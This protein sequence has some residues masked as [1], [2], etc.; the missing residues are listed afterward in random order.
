MSL[1]FLN[2]LYSQETTVCYGTTKV[3]SVDTD[4]GVNGTAGS[5]YS[6][7]IKNADG[8][9]NNT[10]VITTTTTSGNTISV[11]WD[12]TSVGTYTL[13]VVEDNTS[14]VASAVT[15]SVNIK[16]N[17]IVA[18]T[19]VS[20]CLA[21]DTTILAT[22]NPSNGSDIFDW[23]TPVAYTGSTNSDTLT[24]T[25]AAANMAGN[26]TVTVTDTDGC[27]SA[28]AVAVLTVNP[29]PDATIIPITTTEFCSGG[30]VVLSAPTGL[31]YVWNKDGVPIAPISTGD[32]YTAVQSGSYTVTTKD[33][34]NCSSTT[35][36][37]ISV[38]VNPNPTVSVVPSTTEFCDGLSAT[39]TA[40]PGL[41]TPPYSYQWEDTNGNITTN[42]TNASYIATATSDYKVKITDDKGCNVTSDVQSISNRPNPDSSVSAATPTTFCAGDSVVLQSGNAARSGYTYQW[43]KDGVDIATASTN[44]NYTANESGSFTVRVVDTNFSTNCTTS[45][46]SAIVVT[47]T[48]LPITSGITAH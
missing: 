37:G 12:T 15:L 41:G 33:T 38:I 3:Y 9:V 42:G 30:S 13:E 44:F 48:N 27:V 11:N 43:I 16:A 8:T 23:T 21:A 29:L 20:V 4:D 24:I 31:S 2:S 28:P 5:T 34:N 7:K 47:K 19:N 26:Y 36:P 25:T 14:C 45:T 39:L 40:T 1:L 6:W 22:S 46:T 32:S 10:P 17:P 18:T 35:N